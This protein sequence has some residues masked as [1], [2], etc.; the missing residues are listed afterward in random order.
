M[1]SLILSMILLLNSFSEDWFEGRITYQMSLTDMYGRPAFFPI[2]I[3]DVYYS[4]SMKI[5]KVIEG[6]FRYTVGD[7]FLLIDTEKKTR[8]EVW[9]QE[10]RIVDI[11]KEP[12]Q[13]VYYSIDKTKEKE[14]ILGYVCSLYKIKRKVVSEMDTTY[15]NLYA[16]DRLEIPFSSQL[17][18]VG[19]NLSTDGINGNISGVPLKI[20][21]QSKT[22]IIKQEAIEIKRGKLVGTI[23]DYFEDL[24]IVPNH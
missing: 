11:G 2:Q 10:K 6:E 19:G 7:Y 21:I 13:E 15:I 17:V 1:K 12:P 8:F 9:S 5:T 22:G 23:E 18:D 20:I 24:R 14:S 4:T 3:E 16:S